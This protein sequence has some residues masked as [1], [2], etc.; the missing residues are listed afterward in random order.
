VPHTIKSFADVQC[1]HTYL[2]PRTQS[3]GPVLRH[4]GK[5]VEGLVPAAK[6]K[7]VRVEFGAEEALEPLVNKLLENLA[8]DRSKEM[9]L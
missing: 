9:G 1:D 5:E 6:A 7:L 8:H 2:L 4:G 3:I